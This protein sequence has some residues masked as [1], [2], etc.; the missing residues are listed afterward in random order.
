MSCAGC[1]EAQAAKND[2][3]PTAQSE[4]RFRNFIIFSQPMFDT[5]TVPNSPTLLCQKH[6][7]RN[8]TYFLLKKGVVSCLRLEYPCG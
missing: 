8:P 1:V 3:D 6:K 4:R 7:K 2:K 5:Y